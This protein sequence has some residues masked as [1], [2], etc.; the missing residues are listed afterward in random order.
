MEPDTDAIMVQ[1]GGEIPLPE[2]T[3]CINCGECI[4]VCPTQVPVNML[5]RFLEAKQYETAADEYDLYSCVECGLCSFVC[6]SKIPISQYIKL[7][8]FE[9]GLKDTEEASNE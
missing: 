8:K 2:D 5:V 6:V 1:G 7:A 4:R 3:P 9:L